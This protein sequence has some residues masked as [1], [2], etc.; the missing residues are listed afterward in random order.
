MSS[1]DE[2]KVCLRFRPQSSKEK[3]NGGNKCVNIIKDGQGVSTTVS[4]ESLDSDKHVFSFDQILSEDS[5]QQDVYDLAGKPIIEEFLKGKNGCLLAYGQTGAGKT[6]TMNGNDTSRGIIPRVVDSIFTH[7]LSTEASVEFSICCSYVEI[8]NEKIRDLLDIEKNNLNLRTSSTEGRTDIIGS[9]QIYVTSQDEMN[10]VM[11]RGNNNRKVAATGMNAGS[12]RSHSLFLIDL[13]Q[14]NESSGIKLSSRLVLVDLA[15]SEM[16]RKTGAK[17]DRLEEAKSIN[18]SLSALGN[19]IN[20]LTEE[21]SRSHVPYRDS[22][23]TRILRENLGG[24]SITCLILCCSPSSDN[25]Y[26]TL[27]TLRFGRRAKNIKNKAVVNS[28]ASPAEL[29]ARLKKLEVELLN[30]QAREKRLGKLLENALE[31]FKSFKNNFEANDDVVNIK[32][33]ITSTAEEK[34]KEINKMDND[35]I[36]NNNNTSNFNNNNNNNKA[37]TVENDDIVNDDDEKVDILLLPPSLP[38]PMLSNED[39]DENTGEDQGKDTNENESINEY[40]IKSTTLFQ[41][42]EAQF[43]VLEEKYEEKA[44]ELKKREEELN[45]ANKDKNAMM[46][47]VIKDAQ[48][49][50]TLQMELESANYSVAKLMEDAPN[51][52]KAKVRE[53]EGKRNLIANNYKSVLQENQELRREVEVLEHLVLKF[54][55]ELTRAKIELNNSNSTNSVSN[56]GDTENNDTTQSKDAKKIQTNSPSP[57]RF[58]K[59]VR[60]GSVIIASPPRR[61]DSNIPRLDITVKN[62]QKY[63]HTISADINTEITWDFKL[64]TADIGFSVFYD[65]KPVRAYIRCNVSKFYYPKPGD[66]N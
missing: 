59:A 65:E 62:R 24:N 12:S 66:Y 30:S 43:Q 35:N 49:L 41:Q 10:E 11:E 38:P 42:Q 21:R 16:V 31:R 26:E 52:L 40:K 33:K 46:D 63:E 15:G 9:T 28:E 37:T 23:L 7:A 2:I 29:K 55:N 20:A 25:D 54:Q 45:L 61:L 57:P 64:E 13:I 39:P 4:L 19:V 17:G 32:N 60:G 50:M 56:N 18:R 53:M 3:K 8:Y 27:S 58:K 34:T 22:K 14:A 1:T 36:D 47:K 44:I 6:H 48:R 51:Y 5:S